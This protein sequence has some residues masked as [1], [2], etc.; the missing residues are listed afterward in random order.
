MKNKRLLKILGIALLGVTT[1][2][3]IS[4][5]VANAAWMK[6]NTGWWYTEGSSWSVG[7]RQIDG[8]WY[9]FDANGYMK[10]GWVQDKGVW[11]YMDNSGA[12]K[13]GWINDNGVCYFLEDSGAMATGWKDIDGSTYYFKESGEAANGIVEIGDSKYYFN[14]DS[15]RLVRGI[16]LRTFSTNEDGKITSKIKT[17]W[18]EIDTTKKFYINE[19]GSL[20]LGWIEDGNSK[21][22]AGKNGIIV[23]GVQKIDGKLY[24]FATY[25]NLDMTPGLKDYYPGSS[26]VSPKVYL[27]E[28]GTFAK[29]WQEVD[30]KK[31]YF[32]EDYKSSKG[33]NKINSGDL[34]YF[35]GYN[36]ELV[37]NADYYGITTDEN[38]S[39]KKINNYLAK[40]S[41]LNNDSKVLEELQKKHGDIDLEYKGIDNICNIHLV[42][43]DIIN[44]GEG[45]NYSYDDD[46]E[47]FWFRCKSNSN[48]ETYCDYYVS[49]KTGNIY[50]I[51][52]DENYNSTDN[53]IIYKIKDNK[54]IEKYLLEYACV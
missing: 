4:P 5:K 44:L 36:S 42:S 28:D 17:G 31:Y 19:D 6:N 1:L 43:M 26:K 45:S 33:I 23:S 20:H 27:K 50:V 51:Y 13:T 49:V 24:Y 29:G 11:Y 41:I 10:T 22:Y 37:T 47:V 54:K 53:R 16:A 30:D 15:N 39:V 40:N 8:A 2:S 35:N 48:D 21:Y 12:M 46:G 32:N 52:T 18:N 38:G 34:Y 7:W 14:C 25:G 3:T 9:Y